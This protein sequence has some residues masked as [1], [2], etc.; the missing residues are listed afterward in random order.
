MAASWGVSAGFV[1]TVVVVAALLPIAVA[2]AGGPTARRD[3]AIAAVGV[4]AWIALTG[5]LAGS[6]ALMDWS[7]FPPAPIRPILLAV[8]VVTAL[9]AAPLGAAVC[10]ASR[11]T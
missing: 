3:A 4:A 11:L 6:G 7:A 1:A 5:A 9:T 10:E 8:V 2:K